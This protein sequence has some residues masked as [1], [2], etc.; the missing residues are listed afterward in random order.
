MKLDDLPVPIYSCRVKVIGD[1]Y[2]VSSEKASYVVRA[3]VS[4]IND[5][6]ITIRTTDSLFDIKPID[7][8]DLESLSQYVSTNAAV[9]GE[10]VSPAQDG[11]F[12]IRLAGFSCSMVELGRI[13]VGVDEAGEASFSRMRQDRH[14][15]ALTL[16]RA[17]VKFCY[18]TDVESYFFV[19]AGHV[20]D[21]ELAGDTDVAEL[22]EKSFSVVGDAIH[23]IA[24]EK[25]RPDGSKIYMMKGLTVNRLGSDKYRSIR[26]VKGSIRLVD[27]SKAAQIQMM[28]QA[29]MHELV[30][31]FSGYLNK[32]IGFN[33]FEGEQLLAAA[34]KV[35][36]IRYR[37]A[38]SLKGGITTMK[39]TGINR[40][41]RNILK[42]HEISE[43]QYVD[44]EPEYIGN[45]DLSFSE[46]MQ[47]IVGST[48]TVNANDDDEYDYEIEPAR[49]EAK[50]SADKERTSSAD[51]TFA[52][53]SYN[54][55]TRELRLKTDSVILPEC[56]MLVFSTVGYLV[57][58]QRRA[59]AQ[60]YVIDGK[61]ANPEL[62]LIIEEKGELSKRTLPVTREPLSKFVK[63]EFFRFGTTPNQLKA[64]DAALN[65][66]D[67]A[68]IQ[69][70]P[71][72]G[73]TTVIAA[74]YARLYELANYKH[75]FKGEVLL[76]G[77]QH[78]AV[79]NMTGR[80]RCVNS[81]PI[82][83]MGKKNT[84]EELSESVYEAD[85]REWRTQIANSIREKN[86]QLYKLEKEQMVREVLE[87]YVH[88]PTRK[89][90][91]HLVRT[92]SE[93]GVEILGAEMK[94]LADNNLRRLEI[95]DHV[96]DSS[97]NALAALYNL[98]TSEISFRDDGVE[99]AEEFLDEWEQELTD[100]ESELVG[101]ACAWEQGDPLDFLPELAELKKELLVQSTR[102][103]QFQVERVDE[104]LV[105]FACRAC[106]VIR[107]HGVTKD[108]LKS[109][110]LLEFLRELEGNPRGIENSIDD[111]NL[112]YAATCQQSVHD[113]VKRHKGIFG[114]DLMTK[115]PTY[116]YVIVDEA[117]RVGP[118]DLLISMAQ[119]KRILLVG[120]HRQ[121]PQLVDED[122]VAKMESE[123]EEKL[124]ENESA[125][126]DPEWY[127]SSLFQY[128]FTTRI[129]E[130][131]KKYGKLHGGLSRCVTLNVQYR[132][133][134]LLGDFIS[135]NFYA[136]FNSDEAFTS[137]KKESDFYHELPGADGCPCMWLEV[138]DDEPARRAGTSWVRGVEQT[139]ILTWLREWMKCEAGRNLSFGVISFYK[140]QSDVIAEELKP[141]FEDEMEGA[142]PRLRVG[143]VDA[144]QGMEFDVVFLSMVRTPP[145][146]HK[147]VK[148]PF[149]HLVLYNRLN[150]A[151]S[152]Q[153]RLL[154]VVGDPALLDV[155]GANDTAADKGIPG[156]VDFYRLCKEK[157]V[158]RS[159]R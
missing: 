92:I 97:N 119:G 35:G 33:D 137:G 122:K 96:G 10:L 57:Q 61:S 69:G 53:K 156:L 72:T 48:K 81:V 78:D 56:G 30:R 154:V 102:P 1:N 131:E 147:H 80:M 100:D 50:D 133:H 158:V 127:K 121:L 40:D 112:A 114:R 98:R 12:E 9:L 74:I 94:E 146:E 82:R 42:A 63:E 124:A 32:W 45:K 87:Q 150:V 110:A 108:D 19:Q 75:D 139:A 85:M 143:T 44:A 15:E 89:W 157:G 39:V 84:G 8:S 153:K 106:N 138:R 70:P 36:T 145:D 155:P 34:R 37:D 5:A 120:D 117:A 159:W 55:Q 136:R 28:A 29:Q 67:I 43:L 31:D 52:I 6:A 107:E 126:S 20:L 149:G 24:S 22:R 135:R 148:H 90:A 73:K 141:E 26:L 18:K 123:R 76:S 46:M 64:L 58:F 113:S 101:R 3:Q 88:A 142:T 59:L 4:D 7:P 140:A 65:T 71:G 21:E 51:R 66:P 105:A 118:L 152:R 109:I 111:Y 11:S 95:E 104:Q 91:L 77:F 38:A 83:K 132:M 103:P 60:K 17:S 115:L 25:E 16:E 47:Q 93:L 23:F 99:Q 68:L 134:P 144:F 27:W 125:V 116:Q 2:K 41:A 54:D 130:L 86:P 151:M 129:P 14:D 79:E 128:L 13:E 49:V 62:G